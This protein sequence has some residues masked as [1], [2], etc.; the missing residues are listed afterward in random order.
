MLGQRAL[1]P[2]VGAC[3]PKKQVLGFSKFPVGRDGGRG[4]V[5]V[6][7]NSS[8]DVGRW[9]PTERRREGQ[10]HSDHHF[11]SWLHLCPLWG[12]GK[13]TELLCSP[14]V[15]MRKQKQVPPV[16]WLFPHLITEGSRGVLK[17]WSWAQ[18]HQLLLVPGGRSGPALLLISSG[19]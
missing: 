11:L 6:L 10:G 14:H 7:E 8:R 5:G 2:L 18:L 1:G 9:G 17:F 4:C 15:L 3:V 12:T 13:V 16:L 19:S